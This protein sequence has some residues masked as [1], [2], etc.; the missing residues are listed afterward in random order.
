[1][2]LLKRCLYDAAKES[3]VDWS[4]DGRDEGK[5]TRRKTRDNL[6]VWLA[7]LLFFEGF[8]G[9]V[10]IL[11]NDMEGVWFARGGANWEFKVR[12]WELRT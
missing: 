9:T 11:L 2:C 4:N 7:P 8:D 3:V 10:W 5:V 1:M 12:Y 6:P